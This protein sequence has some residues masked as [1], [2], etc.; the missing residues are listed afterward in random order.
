MAR[1]LEAQMVLSAILQSQDKE[2][3][4]NNNKRMAWGQVLVGRLWTCG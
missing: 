3:E 1:E 2:R 4:D